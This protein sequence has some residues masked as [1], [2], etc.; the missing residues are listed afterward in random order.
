MA[1]NY[2]LVWGEKVSLLN[3]DIFSRCFID[4]YNVI[5]NNIEESIIYLKDQRILQ[6]YYSEKDYKRIKKEHGCYFLVKQNIINLLKIYEEIENEF[7][8]LIQ[9][10][11]QTN[12]KKLS[13]KELSL[14]F[15]IYYKLQEKTCAYYRSTRPEA[16][17]KPAE[18]LKLSLGRFYKKEEI[19]NKFRILIESNKKDLI[20]QEKFDWLKIIKKNQIE[21]T[22]LLEHAKKNSFLFL[23]LYK[24]E[25]VINFLKNRLSNDIK[26]INIIKD[27]I[28]KSLKRLKNL[29]QQQN[30][31][32]N[33]CGFDD[34]VVTYSQMFQ[35]FGLYRL[36]LKSVWTGAEFL[37]LPLFEE[38]CGRI[39]IDI[40]TFFDCYTVEDIYNY[41]ENQESL[42]DIEIEKRK[43]CSLYIIKNK[44]NK[45][46][47]GDEALNYIKE[48]V[49]K[50]AKQINTLKGTVANQGL[51][52]GRIKIVPST[53]L[54]DL[55]DIA[56]GFKKGDILV[57]D[58][59][60]PHMI[61]IM[62]KA[63]AIITNVGGLTSHA[64]ILSR[65]L[66]IP[67]IV[68]T[69]KATKVLKDGDFVEVD[70]F[71]GIVRRIE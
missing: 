26:K 41:L 58:M 67:C 63:G 6:A 31:I 62:E 54:E 50:I 69:L 59:T 38:I 57:T 25:Q 27:D 13:L 49:E 71:K 21:N 7:K 56:K 12:L 45:L 64:A 32:L 66:N 42:N 40:N 8:L 53:N 16:E 5:G 20:L 44:K 37:C 33:E 2:V 10:V 35:N 24:Y 4:F 34:D 15:T 39:N 19:E 30:E 60:Q 23:N 17:I 61:F 70:A 65:E 48:K 55:S 18:R 46:L 29:A 43:H 22:L 14:L 36:R 9:K 52:N 47:V 11:K 3:I 1:S 28:Q 68:G 51:V